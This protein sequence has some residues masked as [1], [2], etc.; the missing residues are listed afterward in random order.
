MDG[1]AAAAQ[2]HEMPITDGIGHRKSRSGPS[3][4]VERRSNGVRA[5]I[6][7]TVG[8]EPDLQPCL[9]LQHAHQVGIPHGRERVILHRAF[10]QE[11][12]TDE[13]MAHVNGA[14]IGGKSRANKRYFS[15][16]LFEKRLG[17]GA[18]IAL[19]GGVEGGAVLEEQLPRP[20]ANEASALAR[21]Q[22]TARRPDWCAI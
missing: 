1:P 8:N 13:E 22:R 12:I 21:D 10:V 9:P 18:D 5:S 7:D 11:N 17:N 19:V 4:L 2:R 15:P 6:N 20:R 3:S 14:G 16:H